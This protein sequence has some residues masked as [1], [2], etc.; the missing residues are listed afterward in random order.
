MIKKS[1]LMNA[2]KG[3]EILVRAAG[4]EFSVKTDRRN[5]V[6]LYEHMQGELWV[7]LD[8]GT[9]WVECNGSQEYGE[10]KIQIGWDV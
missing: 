3:H 10:S 2:V 1:E 7:V 8:D 5:L 4:S 9:A 6:A